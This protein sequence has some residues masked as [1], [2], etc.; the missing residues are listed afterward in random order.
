[1]R[2]NAFYLSKI[3]ETDDRLSSSLSSSRG[4]FFPTFFFQLSLLSNNF[5]FKQQQTTTLALQK[6]KTNAATRVVKV[7]LSS[8]CEMFSIQSAKAFSFLSRRGKEKL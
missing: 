2:F 6:K 3:S 4:V 7:L 8:S 1:V 5:R